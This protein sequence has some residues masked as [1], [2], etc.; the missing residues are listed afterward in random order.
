MPVDM[1]TV[2]VERTKSSRAFPDVHENSGQ[3]LVSKGE[4]VQRLYKIM[5]SLFDLLITSWAFVTTRARR[6][7]SFKTNLG[8]LQ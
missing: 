8:F 1:I 6:K 4:A 3:I 5:E 2:A 7:I